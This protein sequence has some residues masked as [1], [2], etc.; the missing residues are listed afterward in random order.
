MFRH[1]PILLIIFA[2]T[3]AHAEQGFFEQLLDSLKSKTVTTT[4]ETAGEPADSIASEPLALQ[5]IT[6]TRRRNQKRS[7]ASRRHS[8]SA[9]LRQPEARTGSPPASSKNTAQSSAAEPAVPPELINDSKPV[10]S[11]L[12]LENQSNVLPSPTV[13]PDSMPAQLAPWP[14]ERSRVESAQGD[15]P[16]GLQAESPPKAVADAQPDATEVAQE[17]EPEPFLDSQRVVLAGFS[18][19]WLALGIGMFVFRRQLAKALNARRRQRP[20]AETRPHAPRALTVVLRN[21]ARDGTVVENGGRAERRVVAA[22]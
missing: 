18:A 4:S 17:A 19:T 2:S 21:A 9:P 11:V 16:R 15:P 5:P 12:P 20:H 8:V 7:H 6:A 13:W 14:D 3:S 1:L 22:G 10:E